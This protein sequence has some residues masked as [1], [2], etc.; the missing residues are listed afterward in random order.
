MKSPS[1]IAKLVTINAILYH[2]I[3]YIFWVG[4]YL[5]HNNRLTVGPYQGPL[6]CQ[7]LPY[8]EGACWYSVINRQPLVI[9]DVKKFQ[10]HIACDPRS[11]SELV[12]PLLTS[13]DIIYGVLD[14]DSNILNAFDKDDLDAVLKIVNLL[15]LG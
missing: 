7:E 6:A 2:K 4:V 9:S 3:P 5:H 1:T 13:K 8:P 11:K 15:Q 14:I 12:I 10:G